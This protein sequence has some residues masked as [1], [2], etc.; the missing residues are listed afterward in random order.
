M[1]GTHISI[2]LELVCCCMQFEMGMHER[3]L[4]VKNPLGSY[5]SYILEPQK[6]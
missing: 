1:S 6:P 2:Y 5:P 4:V 3:D